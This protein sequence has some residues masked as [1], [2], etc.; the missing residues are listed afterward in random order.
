MNFCSNGNK[1]IENYLLCI[2]SENFLQY[3]NN[4]IL[5]IWTID[6]DPGKNGLDLTLSKKIWPDLL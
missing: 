5:G 6:E 1:S 2:D 3:L 4:L